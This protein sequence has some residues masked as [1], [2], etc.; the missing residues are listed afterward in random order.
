MKNK[1]KMNIFQRIGNTIEEDKKREKKRLDRY[2][3]LSSN[4]RVE[5]DDK[6]DRVEF[7]NYFT[8]KKDL[9]TGKENRFLFL[10]SEMKE[11]KK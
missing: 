6:L 11:C 4:E 5:Y 7:K 3:K 2:W 1:N 8:C 9:R 10:D